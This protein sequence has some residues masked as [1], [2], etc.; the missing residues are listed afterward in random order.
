MIRKS[1]PAA[2]AHVSR[3]ESTCRLLLRGFQ[4]CLG[5][6]GA[7]TATC[8]WG[9][10]STSAGCPPEVRHPQVDVVLHLHQITKLDAEEA[11]AGSSPTRRTV[12]FCVS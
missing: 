1:K 4:C 11:N 7:S 12:K 10:P 9:S 8:H 2:R 3:A 5:R 6:F